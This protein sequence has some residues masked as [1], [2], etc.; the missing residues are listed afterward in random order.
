MLRTHTHTG[1]HLHIFAQYAIEYPETFVSQFKVLLWLQSTCRVLGR[2]I[3]THTHTPANVVKLPETKRL[4]AFT[5]LFTLSHAVAINGVYYFAVCTL[6]LGCNFSSG[7]SVAML[8]KGGVG[9]RACRHQ[10]RTRRNDKA[11]KTPCDQ[12]KGAQ[13]YFQSFFISYHC[14]RASPSDRVKVSV[15]G[16]EVFRH[17]PGNRQINTL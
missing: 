2:Y 14:L 3:L 12:F 15:A 5:L 8:V 6:T 4:E 1:T 9:R 10:T 17:S 11:K 7:P 16:V 13:K